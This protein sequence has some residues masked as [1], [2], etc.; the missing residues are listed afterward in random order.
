MQIARGL[1]ALRTRAGLAQ[2][3]V[4]KRAGVSVGTVNRY[5]TWQD[6]AKAQSADCECTGGYVRR[7]GP[8]ARSLRPTRP[9]PGKRLV[10]GSPHRTRGHGPGVVVRGCRRVRAC[11]RQRPGTRIL[12][13][14]NY[15]LALHEAQDARA[16][17]T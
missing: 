11:L 7:D 9:E 3:E 14:R 13:T 4:A 17:P 6:R 5:E 8:G 15:A 1:R 12:Q 16:G 2:S 10:D